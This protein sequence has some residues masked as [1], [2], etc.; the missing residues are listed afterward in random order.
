MDFLYF[1]VLHSFTSSWVSFHSRMF[2]SDKKYLRLPFAACY[3][4]L[5]CLK[6]GH[7][8]LGGNEHLPSSRRPRP[9][10]KKG[11]HAQKCFECTLYT[12]ASDC[13]GVLKAFQGVRN[14]TTLQLI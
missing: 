4:L 3:I 13:K 8:T 1:Q 12:C 7:F 6:K 9:D 11:K 14:S 5:R 10:L 2:D